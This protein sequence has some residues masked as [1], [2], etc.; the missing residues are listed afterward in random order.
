MTSY[1]RQVT[2]IQHRDEQIPYSKA[3]ARA[4]PTNNKKGGKKKENPKKA[5][6]NTIA[7]NKATSSTTLVRTKESTPSKSAPTK[8]EQS[9]QST[10]T[11]SLDVQ[12]T[13]KSTIVSANDENQVSVDGESTL[14]AADSLQTPQKSNQEVTL[15]ESEPQ[16]AKSSTDQPSDNDQSTDSASVTKDTAVGGRTKIVTPIADKSTTKKV[17]SSSNPVPLVKSTPAVTT[18]IIIPEKEENAMEAVLPA[19]MR[20]N[21][22]CG[23][24]LTCDTVALKRKSKAF[25]CIDRIAFLM[26]GKHKATEIEACTVAAGENGPCGPECHPTLCH[27]ETALQPPLL[28]WTRVATSEPL[29]EP[30]VKYD[31]VVMVTKVL[32]PSEL[33]RLKQMICLFTAAYNRHVN[34]DIVVFTTIPWTRLQILELQGVAPQTN[35]RVVVDS[36]PLQD[37]L[38]TMSSDELKFLYERCSVNPGENITWLHHCT[39]PGFRNI[40]NLGYAWQAEFRA[41]HIWNTPVLAEY[42]YMIWMDSDALCTKPWTQDPMKVVVENDLVL[43]FDNFPQ[44]ACTNIKLQDKLMAAYNRTMCKVYLV[45][46]GHL[47]PHE[48]RENE[49]VRVGNVHGFHHITNLD[50]YRSP[51]HQHF[52]QIMVSDYRFSREW[53]DQLGVTVPAAMGAPK[54][55]WDYRA[56]G[57]NMGIHHNGRLDGKEKNIAFGYN[58]FWEKGG[59]KNWQVGREMCDNLVVN[60]D[61]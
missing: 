21:I 19:S 2:M 39:E 56:H 12:D 44:G 13:R 16:N 6:M 47:N 18:S 55:A 15:L 52:L 31:R 4:R 30:F 8:R 7:N 50:Y 48:C 41:Y 26:G 11:E 42:K 9:I 36:P 60:K 54:R 28:N 51:E 5:A 38:A 33:M 29:P 43:L 40:A 25:T 3:K 22:S 34:Y 32:W 10:P 14:I 27:N 46:G 35:I 24:P 1:Q 49:S 57:L 59:K 23:C 20:F 53:D 58:A 17:S 37:Q 45:D 61:R